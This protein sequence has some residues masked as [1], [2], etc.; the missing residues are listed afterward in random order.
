MKTEKKKTKKQL[1]AEAEH[2]VAIIERI[3]THPRT[4]FRNSSTVTA[5]DLGLTPEQHRI[6]R[7]RIMKAKKAKK[8]IAR[9]P[10]TKARGIRGKSGLTICATWLKTF[11]TKSIKTA[12]AC[13]KKMKTEFPKRKS[14]IF[15]FP[16]VVVSRANKGLLDGKNHKFVKYAS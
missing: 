5:A 6:E 4:A 11:S 7:N 12:T 15:N 2:S 8:A 9:K 13:T 14:A 3:T 10:A 16:N 1:K